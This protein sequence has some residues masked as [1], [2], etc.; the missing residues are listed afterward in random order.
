MDVLICGDIGGTH[1][2][3]ALFPPGRPHA[4][5]ATETFAS[6]EFPEFLPLL[7]RFLDGRRGIHVRGAA[8][9]I[10]GPASGESEELWMVNLPWRIRVSEVARKL[11]VAH[12]RF[13]NDFAAVAL[14]VPHLRPEHLHALGGGPSALHAP[15]AVLGAGTGLGE[16]FL[17]WTGTCYFAVAT[18]CGHTDFAPR[19]AV[20]M[21]LLEYLRR[22]Y[23]GV[24][25]ERVLSG[26]GLANLA[27]FLRDQEGLEA[28]P[29]LRIALADA[30]GRDD[31]PAVITRL[32]SAATPDPLCARAIE[33]FCAL[34]G[35][36]AGNA[37]LR[38]V[39]KGGVYL[40]GGIAPLI[41]EPL[42]RGGF[43]AAFE[44]KQ[45]FSDLLREL[46]VWIVTH[47]NPG[48][49]GAA[50]AAQEDMEPVRSRREAGPLTHARPETASH[51][52]PAR[53]IAPASKRPGKKLPGRSV[54][55]KRRKHPRH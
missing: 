25:W 16:S 52:L 15:I 39:A 7:S 19:T 46:P 2:R 35:A 1:T 36:E 23:G 28:P 29:P 42:S 32:A 5:V 47:P 48:L 10:P 4:F 45:G 38:V 43:R 8:F 21:R 12:V 14:A 9:G 40:A 13:V 44:A 54:R 11:G 27:E 22:R 30:T 26:P 49:L 37:A 41:R 33:M 3:L 53:R 20:E 51:K 17:V 18:E 24:T 50:I 55:T 31:A 34:Y 6:R